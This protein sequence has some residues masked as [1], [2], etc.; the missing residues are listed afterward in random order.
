[1]SK[2]TRVLKEMSWQV[3]LHS[4]TAVSKRLYRL[5]RNAF[6]ADGRDPYFQRAFAAA[7]ASRLQGDYLEFGVYKGDSVITASRL[8]HDNSLGSMRFFA[9]DC[10]EGMPHSE[11]W[12]QDGTY[13]CSEEHF[14]RIITKAGVD[15]DRTVIVK[16]L[17]NDT[18]NDDTKEKHR[19]R[20]AAIVHIDCDLYSSTCEVLRFIE[21]LIDD[22][23]IIIF[24]DWHI[25]G[26]DKVFTV[27]E[28]KAFSEWPLNKYCH[29]LFDFP[30]RSKGFVF[31]RS[32]SE[33]DSSAYPVAPG[34]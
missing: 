33:N 10:F 22:G 15:M 16:G 27:G 9:F 14:T 31:N 26:P 5:G 7:G 23:T 21:N 20:K 8:A 32:G 25:Y 34:R 6:I 12:L 18:L 2:L 29:E 3:Y 17:F 1:M 4:P 24:D 30:G 19:L 13:A 28:G 11:D